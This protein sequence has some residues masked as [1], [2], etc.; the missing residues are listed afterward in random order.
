MLKFFLTITFLLSLFNSARSEDFSEY[1]QCE[2]ISEV[3]PDASFKIKK[4]IQGLAGSLSRADLIYKDKVVRSIV[5]G[6]SL[7]YSNKYWAFETGMKQNKDGRIIL[8]KVG[9]GKRIMFVGN[10]NIPERSLVDNSESYK[11]KPRKVLL[12][13]LGS[14]LYRSKIMEDISDYQFIDAAEG[15]WKYND[16]CFLKRSIDY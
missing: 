10:E 11:I 9:G 5:Y 13:N 1:T 6:G 3:L 16:K 8:E 15:Y 2:W 12:V 7:G 14:Y 4:H